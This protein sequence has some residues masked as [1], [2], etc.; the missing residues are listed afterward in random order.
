MATLAKTG[1]GATI[2]YEQDPS[3]AQGTFTVVAEQAGD[4]TWGV[5]RGSTEVTAHNHTADYYVTDGRFNRN[6]ITVPLNFV[7]DN[8]THGP[9][10]TGLQGLLFSNTETGFRLRGPGGTTDTDEWICSGFVTGFTQTNPVR[11][12]ARSAELTIRLSGPMIVDGTTRGADA[13]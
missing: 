2:A 5:T 4:L 7:F 11:E 13:F 12:G 6:E 8:A 10:S 1:H 3:G 9:A